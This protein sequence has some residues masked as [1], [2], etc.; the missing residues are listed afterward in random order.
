MVCRGP[1]QEK[2]KNMAKNETR[3]IAPSI[4]QED[5]DALAA[6]RNMTGYAPANA[7]CSVAKLDGRIDTLVSKRDIETQ[8]QADWDAARDDAVA[9]EWA[10]HNAMLSAKDQVV[11]QFGADSNELQAL[12]YKKKSEF[13]SPS[14]SAPA[15]P[16]AP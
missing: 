1:A 7:D 9:A 5:R 8:K 14:K 10:F 16:K 11:A 4:L 6:L 3:R 15:A 13:K 12:G 2:E